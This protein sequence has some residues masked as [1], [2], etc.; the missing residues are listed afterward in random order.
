MS[1]TKKIPRTGM[2]RFISAPKSVLKYSLARVKQTC[3]GETCMATYVQDMRN[4]ISGKPAPGIASNAIIKHIEMIAVEPATIVPRI[5]SKPNTKNV[6]IGNF[7]N[8][9]GS[10][11]ITLV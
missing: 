6:G 11:V 7:A 2:V 8:R 1:T 9:V 3:V 5:N 10:S 4:T